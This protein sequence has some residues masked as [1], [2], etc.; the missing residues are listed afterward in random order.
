MRV[1]QN[2]LGGPQNMIRIN[3][4]KLLAE[5][6]MTQADLARKTKIRAATIFNM[7][8]NY[9]VDVKLEYIYRICTVLKCSPGDLL[10]LQEED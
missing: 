3:L 7:Y 5:R 10:Q 1:I 4:K 9:S 8:N 6:G 2:S